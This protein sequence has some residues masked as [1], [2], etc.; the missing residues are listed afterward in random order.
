[1]SSFGGRPSAFVESQME[2]GPSSPP[3]T[4]ASAFVESQMEVGPSSPPMT[5]ASAEKTPSGSLRS[6]APPAG[7]PD[8]AAGGSLGELAPPEAGSAFSAGSA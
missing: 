5:P 4:P 1:M 8:G 6:P 7:E 2:V 3:M